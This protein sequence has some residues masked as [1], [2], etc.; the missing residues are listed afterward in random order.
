MQRI[1]KI[2]SV[3]LL[4]LTLLLAA[5][6][7]YYADKF[8]FSLDKDEE[9]L[10]AEQCKSLNTPYPEL[11]KIIK[12]YDVVKIEPWLPNAKPTDHDG[13]VYLNRIYRLTTKQDVEAPLTLISEVKSAST[14]IQGAEREAIM[15]IHAIPDDPMIGNQWYLVKP[16]V[17]E[18]WDL[19]DL[20]GGEI[21][22]D[23]HVVIAIVD[24]GV[25]YT[26]PDL[27]KNIW[28]NQ[29]EIPSLYFNLIDVSPE[30]SFITAEEAVAFCGDINGNGKA[31]LRDVISSNSLLTNTSDTDGDGYI[32]NII[33]WDTNLRGYENDDTYLDDDRDPMPINNSHGTHVAGLAG[34]TT[35][36]GTG[37]ASAGYN[38]SIMPVKATGDE[39][40]DNINTGWAGILC[41]AQSGADIINCS[42]G[43]PGYSH[44]SQ[45]VINTCY[46]QYGA[47]IVA[48]AG[49]GDNSGNPSDEPHYP[50]GYKNVVSVTAVSSSDIFSWANYGAADL[51]NFAGVDISAPGE[52]MYSTYLTKE[53]GYKYLNGTSMASPFVASC[54]GLLK[55]VYPDST[56]NW[57]VNRLL[58]NTDPI[59]DI[60]PD[61]AGQIGSGRVNILKSLVFD[62]WPKLSFE[63]QTETITSGDGDSILNP[64][65]N[66]NLII[67]LKNDPGWATASNVQ[68]VLRSEIEGITILDSLGTWTAI[69]EDSTATNSG[70]G[71]TVQFSNDLLPDDYNFKL[72][73]ESNTA[74]GFPYKEIISFDISLTL[75]QEGFPFYASTAVEASPLF[76]DIDGDGK[77]EIIFGD[78]SGE[79]YVIDHRGDTLAGF[80]KSLGSQIGGVAVA[81]IDLDDT[82]EI[83]ATAFDKLIQVYDVYGNHEWTRHADFF[84]TAI[85]AIGN[86]DI[87]PE[88]EVVVGS[89]DQKIYAINHDSTDVM[90]FPYA[91][92]QLLHGGVSLADVNG[93]GLDD[94]IYG[95][96]G[97]QCSIVMADGSTPTGWPVTTSGSITSEPQVIITGD[98]TAIILIGNDMG[99]MYGFDLDGTQRFMIDGY[100]SI[101]T[102]PAIYSYGDNIYA[103]FATSQGRIYKVDIINNTLENGWPKEVSPIH[104]SLAIADIV[105]DGN[106]K[107]Q[108]L[109]MG[110]DGYIYAFDM[111][112]NRVQGYPLNTGLLSKSGLAVTDIDDDGDN[113]LIS[114]NYSGL[115]VIDLK[116]FAGTVYW[117]MHRGSADRRGSIA[118]ILTGID[119]VNI[120]EEFELEL[121]GNAPNPFNPM[122]TISYRINDIT[123]LDL[124]IY[125]LDGKLVLS[126]QITNPEYGMNEININMT[127]FS[128]GIYLYSLE[129]RNEIRKAKM[130]YLK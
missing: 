86:V 57:L 9:V 124:R 1:N 120:P 39:T 42:W 101:K 33:G 111:E 14:A 15:R 122:T 12:K 83:V 108:V 104:Q 29:D 99:N 63:N 89:Y 61:Y 51:A 96:K 8:L 54:L 106:E 37:I 21:P 53:G 43:G 129:S 69:S 10:T 24:D 78:K 72:E 76:V 79:L 31:D 121:I 65:E 13:D 49:N 11:N 40:V 7:A 103:F 60:N 56:N 45:T 20:E 25:E 100:G 23:R 125:S 113:D 110:N 119:D 74:G 67:E 16:Q 102:S 26:H 94:I 30:D 48:A 5:T 28:I 62:K 112:G 90:T 128:S 34:A 97:G 68:G 44:S 75:D 18:A 66:I 22:G 55:S 35:N 71:F 50:S 127:G 80:P 115:S 17:K 46:N 32:D 38:V 2:L 77:Q 117:S 105:N 109:A 92:G 64:G 4:S 114:G 41:A 126:R 3:L 84:I 116:N 87:D 118:K 82:L 52:S 70:N 85:P 36:N 98:N 91:T 130:I 6:P 123:S 58:E 73:L 93:D 59:D 47:I 88:L 95:S 107:S 27:W 19:W 81:D